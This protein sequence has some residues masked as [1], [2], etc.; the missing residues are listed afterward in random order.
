MR[1]I[2]PIPWNLIDRL[3]DM[4]FMPE[5]RDQ[6]ANPAEQRIFQP[7]DGQQ[8]FDAVAWRAALGAY[9]DIPFMD[10]GRDQGTIADDENSAGG[11]S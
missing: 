2:R 6:P 10:D 9:Q 3:G 7:I 1:N 11:G 4:P 8:R 5:G